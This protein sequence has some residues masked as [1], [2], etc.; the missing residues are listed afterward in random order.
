MN[1]LLRLAAAAILL[2]TNLVFAATAGRAQFVAGDVKVESADGIQRPLKKGDS[3]AEGEAVVTGASGQA[4]LLMSDEAIVAVRADTRLRFETYRFSGKPDGTEESLIGLLRGGF[5]TISGLIGRSKP[6]AYKIKTP[7]ATIGIRGTDHEPLYIPPPEPGETP[8]GPPGTYNKVNSGQTFIENASGRIEIGPNQAGYAPPTPTIAPVRLPQIPAFM[9]GTPSVGVVGDK[10]GTGDAERRGQGAKEAAGGQGQQERGEG[11]ERKTQVGPQ[12]A[13]R[14][15]AAGSA[16]QPAGLAPQPGGVQGP[17]P[18]GAAAQAPGGLMPPGGI[19]AGPAPGGLQSP[20]PGGLQAPGGM[21][22]PGSI[23]PPVAPIIKGTLDL[24]NPPSGFVAAPNG[25]GMTGGDLSGSAVGSGAGVVGNDFGAVLNAAGN[26]LNVGGGGFSYASGA[27]PL[28]QQGSTTVGGVPVRWGIYAGG[29][30]SDGQGVRNPSFFHFMGA[31]NA[32][33]Q[34]VLIPALTAGGPMTFTAAA[35]N[36]EYTKPVAENGAVGGTVGLSITLNNVSSTPSVT[37]YNLS[38]SDANAR[39]WT[40]SLS[41]GPVGLGTF[42]KGAGAQ[43]NVG[44]TG[45]AAATG[46]GG[47]H[48]VAIGSTSIQGVVSSYDL[49]AG[50]AGVTGSVLA[51]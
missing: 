42:L 2:S 15:G 33:S 26:L 17:A 39:S 16:S 36:N 50:G 28:F 5:R 4:Q 27:A 23:P 51:R 13:T 44:C 30:I 7:T 18:A 11:Q 47:A 41:G 14:D 49:K 40:A 45:C 19:P 34:A 29:Q 6:S 9:R 43:L 46:L 24:N 31:P 21:P 12:S 1:I 8:V 32:T 38:V 35:A 3:I 37:A 48:G 22:L 25:Y 20:M 10:R